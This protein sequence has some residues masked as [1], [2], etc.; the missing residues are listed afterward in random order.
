MVRNIK[1]LFHNKIILERLIIVILYLASNS[2]TKEEVPIDFLTSKSNLPEVIVHGAVLSIHGKQFVRLSKPKSTAIGDSI[3]PISNAQITLFDGEKYYSYKE[4]KIAG[5]Y[6][7]IDSILLSAGKEYSLNI[8]I[9]KKKYV[10]KDE[11]KL[12]NY[13]GVLPINEITYD[14]MGRVYTKSY[15]HNFGFCDNNMWILNHHFDSI[16]N[17]YE[18]LSPKIIMDYP[19]ILFTHNSALP[20]GLFANKTVSTGGAGNSEQIEEYIKL[21]VSDNYYKYLIS[22]FNLTDWSSGLFSTIPGN[23]YTNLSKGATGYF[24]ASDVKKI[25]IKFKDMKAIDE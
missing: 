10:A 22:M 16:G 11:M 24:F 5:E 14:Q 12:C 9:N 18:Y 6:F 4:S 21:S 7:T 1:N 8:K 17:P 20:Q 25:R 13:N 3:I 2:C 23:T 15:I 19:I